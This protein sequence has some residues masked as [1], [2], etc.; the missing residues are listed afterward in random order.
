M[1]INSDLD[2]VPWNPWIDSMEFDSI[3]M[4]SMEIGSTGI[5]IWNLDSTLMGIDSTGI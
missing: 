2:L 3:L 5:W 4:D 1:G